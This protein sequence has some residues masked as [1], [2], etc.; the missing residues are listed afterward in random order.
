M[1]VKKKEGENKKLPSRTCTFLKFMNLFR[2]VWLL[3]KQCVRFPVCFF[4]TCMGGTTAPAAIV[5]HFRHFDAYVSP[6]K[7]E[8]PRNLIK[9]SIL[10]IYLL[11]YRETVSKL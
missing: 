10:I 11:Y 9:I 2:F 5:L 7:Q 6:L 1:I 4:F 8:G 3:R